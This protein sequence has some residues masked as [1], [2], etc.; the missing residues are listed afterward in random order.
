ML[1][2]NVGV[3]DKVDLNVVARQRGLTMKVYYFRNG[4]A[5][6][7]S[8]SSD[9]HNLILHSFKISSLQVTDHIRLKHESTN[10]RGTT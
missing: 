7:A 6:Q 8:I 3:G 5:T 9:A 4:D 10:E 2:K 1:R